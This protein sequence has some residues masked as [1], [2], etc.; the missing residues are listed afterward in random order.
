MQ[1]VIRSIWSLLQEHIFPIPSQPAGRHP[2]FNPYH[3]CLPE[4][5]LPQAQHLRRENLHNYLA[6]FRVTPT[7]LILG[8]APGWRGCRFTGVPF[9]SEA[10]LTSAELPFTGKRTSLRRATSGMASSADSQAPASAGG[11]REA[12]ASIFWRSLAIYSQKFLVWNVFPFHPHQPGNPRSNR[13]PGVKETDLQVPYL[14]LLIDYLK[15]TRILA[16]G[17]FAQ[18]TLN[19]LTI[20]CQPIRHPSHGGARLF[21]KQ[22]LE[23]FEESNPRGF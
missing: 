6:H 23:I 3:D 13:K 21:N 1:P 18:F 15:P 9:T 12:S 5:E 22:V 8:E 17:K 11:Y 7:L 10:Q 4:L 19:R 20:P 16:V 2:Y 14:L